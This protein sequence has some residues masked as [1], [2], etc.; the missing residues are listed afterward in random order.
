MDAKH[1]ETFGYDRASMPI[2]MVA[3]R[4]EAIWRAEKRQ[5][6]SHSPEVGLEA[7]TATHSGA[8]PLYDRQ[9]LKG[10]TKIQGPAIVSSPHS[11][12][13]VEDNWTA[14]VNT[15]NWIELHRSAITASVDDSV[16]DAVEME[17]AARRVQGIADAMGEVIRRTSVSVNVKELSLIHI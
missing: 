5:L 13:V 9:S 1:K 6:D 2:E 8:W 3:L 4:A 16:N 15:E 11:M 10:G 7:K 12:L 17:I 14:S